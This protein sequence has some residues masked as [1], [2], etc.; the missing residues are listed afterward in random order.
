MRAV[1]PRI[2]DAR[3]RRRMAD[4]RLVVD[5]IGAPEGAELAEQI[6]ALV[7]VLGRPDE[8]DGIGAGLFANGQHLVADFVDRLLPGDA[9]P[10]AAFKLERILQAASAMHDLADRRALGAMRAAID[11]AF[12]PGLLPGPDAVFDLGDDGA[13]DRAMRADI[14]AN[15]N[16]HAVEPGAAA[17]R[18]EPSLNCADRCERSGGKS[19]VTEECAA[20]QAVVGGRGVAAWLIAS[21]SLLSTS[22]QHGRHSPFHPLVAIGPIECFYVI[23]FA[24]AGARFLATGVIGLRFSNR[25]ARQRQER[26]QQP[27]F[28]APGKNVSGYDGLSAKTSSPASLLLKS[29]II[30]S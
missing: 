4:A 5:R 1:A 28:Q 16:A 22:D 18:T 23:G 2:G 27:R 14:L 8:I 24:V 21:S 9:F 3:H 10:L 17:A 30:R 6:G 25:L 11:R 29:R 7:G 26:Q 13:A 12:P 20:V 19:G 15:R